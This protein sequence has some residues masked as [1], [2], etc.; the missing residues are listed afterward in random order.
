[1]NKV[2]IVSGGQQGGSV[3]QIHEWIHSPFSPKPSPH[4]GCHITLSSL[5]YSVGPCW[6]SILNIAVEHVSPILP[7]Y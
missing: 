4:P 2:V 3:T 6:L 7:N 5:C 1:M